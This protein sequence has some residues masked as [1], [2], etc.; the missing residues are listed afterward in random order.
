MNIFESLENLNV[1]EECFEDIVQLV[2]YFISE[3]ELDMEKVYNSGRRH[4]ATRAKKLPGEIKNAEKEFTEA[5]SKAYQT[6][7]DKRTNFSS[8]AKDEAHQIFLKIKNGEYKD[9][10]EKHELMKK[11]RELQKAVEDQVK[12]EIEKATKDLDADTEK[13][14]EKMSA[15]KSGETRSNLYDKL[16]DFTDKV[17]QAR[18]EK[19][20]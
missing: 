20:Q 10:A 18:D 14:R 12:P 3:E 15:L 7:Q 13:K 5:K 8:P 6:G 19:E 17:Y 2:E 4:Y 11:H 1:S 9:D 16:N